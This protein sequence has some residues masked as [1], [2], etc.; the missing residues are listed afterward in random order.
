MT[1]LLWVVNGNPTTSVPQDGK[2]FILSNSLACPGHGWISSQI[3]MFQ[4]IRGLPSTTWTLWAYKLELD[5]PII[6]NVGLGNSS[7]EKSLSRPMECTMMSQATRTPCFCVLSSVYHLVQGNPVDKKALSTLTR[8]DLKRCLNMTPSFLEGDY[9]LGFLEPVKERDSEI[10]RS[11]ADRIAIFGLLNDLMRADDVRQAVR[12]MCY[13]K[14]HLHYTGAIPSK[15]CQ[16]RCNQG[17]D[18]LQVFKRGFSR[19]RLAKW[20]KP[21]VLLVASL[22]GIPDIAEDDIQAHINN[23]L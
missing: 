11:V 3:Y 16:S 17:P 1:R 22:G 23:P 13:V 14:F 10:R 9:N 21:C 7:P 15:I 6:I 2:G 12:D 4:P 20:W 5:N 8:R 18:R 19:G